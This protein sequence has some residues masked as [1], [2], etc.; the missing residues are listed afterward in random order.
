MNTS[1]RFLITVTVVITL[2]AV[3]HANATDI[4]VR[5]MQKAVLTTGDRLSPAAMAISSSLPAVG[6]PLF[7]FDAQMRTG[8]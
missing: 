3:F 8:W 7:Q 4:S 6:T 2:A 1:S 5:D